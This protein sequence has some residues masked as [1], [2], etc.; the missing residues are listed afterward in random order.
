MFVATQIKTGGESMAQINIT[1]SQEEVLQVLTG[2]RNEALKFLMERIL[3]SIMKA[4]SEE[5]LGAPRYE[6]T[7]ERQDYRNGVRERRLNTRIGTLVLE[8]PRH[9]NEPFH[10]MVLENYKRSE[11]SLIATMVQM[12]IAGVSTRKVAKVVETLCGTSFS[13][14]T[15]SALCRELDGEIRQFVTSPLDG[16]DAPFLMIDATYFKVREDHRIVSKAFMVALAIKKDGLREVI[17]F[18]VYDAED[19]YSWEHFLQSLKDRGLNTVK[20]VIS[21][22]HRS[23]RKAVANVY[24]KV[25]WQ[26]CQVH[27]ERNILDAAPSKYKEGLKI[28]LRKLFTAKTLEEARKIKNEIVRDYEDV[29]EKAMQ[30]LEDGFED[31]MTVMCLPE[32]IRIVLR[33]TNILERLNRELKRRSD[34]I[35]VFP[36][37]ASVL[38]LMGAVTMEYSEGQ[39]TKQRIFAESKFE[40]LKGPMTIYLEKTAERQLGLLAA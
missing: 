36:N 21:D 9:R 6:R 10:T 19:N 29:A 27:L 39:S 24:P 16:I 23:I 4:E 32:Y 1:L 7:Q 35:Q 12:V 5:Q 3:N 38:R 31:S 34:V 11:A 18:N 28:E 26:R 8:V 40:Y 17:G 30:I 14:S 2:D 33:T 13:K 20:L 15:V 25:A 37:S 22:A